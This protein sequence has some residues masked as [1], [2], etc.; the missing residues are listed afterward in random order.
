MSAPESAGSEFRLCAI[1]AVADDGSIGDGKRMPWHL[2]D[3]FK[4]F[5]AK[6]LGHAVISGRKN[7][8]AMGRP[9]PGRLNIVLTRDP[10]W[11]AEGAMVARSLDEAVE[12][13]RKSG[14]LSPFVIG[15]GEIYRQALPL[16]SALYLTEVHKSYG[17]P[18]RFP[19]FDRAQWRETFREEHPAD[20]RHEAAMSFVVLERISD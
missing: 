3:D 1:A 14:D 20:E 4:W 2:P 15:G 10:A 8:E 17:S 16:I 5:K 12:L 13:A 6:T 9:L 18:V 11:S 19:D 7:F